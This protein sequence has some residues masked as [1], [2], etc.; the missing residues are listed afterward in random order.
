MTTN[1]PRP[2]TVLT[3]LLRTVRAVRTVF[4][5]R[6]ER[7]WLDAPAGCCQ[8][9]TGGPYYRGHAA[10]VTRYLYVGACGPATGRPDWSAC[11]A[12]PLPGLAPVVDYGCDVVV[13]YRQAEDDTART[14]RQTDGGAS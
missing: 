14:P 1:I 9:G 8:C 3:S 13:T 2:R 7:R 12:H 10:P 6:A 11:S 4:T 5:R